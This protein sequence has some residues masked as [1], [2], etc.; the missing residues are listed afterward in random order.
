MTCEGGRD[1]D[2]CG[3]GVRGRE[4]GKGWRG[5]GWVAVKCDDV[6]YWERCGGPGGTSCD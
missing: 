5:K 4:G 3:D 6:W 1:G 2:G